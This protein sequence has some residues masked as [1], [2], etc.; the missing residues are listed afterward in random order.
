M[1]Q[2]AAGKW[3]TLDLIFMMPQIM[4]SHSIVA[5]LTFS[6]PVV[7]WL[8]VTLLMRGISTATNLWPFSKQLLPDHENL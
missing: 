1:A 5:R 7:N 8:L 2:I 6:V 4:I 3:I